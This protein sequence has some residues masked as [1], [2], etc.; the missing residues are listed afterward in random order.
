MKPLPTLFVLGASALAMGFARPSQDAAPAEPSAA[1]SKGTTEP[2][3]YSHDRPA[4]FLIRYDPTRIFLTPHL[5]EALLQPVSTEEAT[6]PTRSVSLNFMSATESQPPGVF[7]GGIH[8]H[9]DA[10]QDLKVRERLL[11]TGVAQL[12]YALNERL[13]QPR[14]RQANES[15]A[16]SRKLL[17]EVRRELNA[18][19]KEL[20]AQSIA[21]NVKVER[22]QLARDL[23][24]LKL[25]L[26]VAE[27]QL[28]E[29]MEEV[30]MGAQELDAVTAKRVLAQQILERVVML[31]RTGNQPQEKLLRA[32]AELTNADQQLLASRAK[33]DAK[34]SNVEFFDQQ[35]TSLNLRLG[36]IAARIA[37]L[38]QTIESDMES[39]G[40]M[41][42]AT[43][44]RMELE[45]TQRILQAQIERLHES[46]AHK[47]EALTSL[48]PVSVERW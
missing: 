17:Q 19:A 20:A 42:N 4:T 40:S 10:P 47:E 48:T 31:V 7:V 34:T 36:L 33:L 30:R 43:A 35:Q 6:D 11:N 32:Q 3:P 39:D 22:E 24:M 21:A 14:Q 9:R 15:R 29:A 5:V 13:T 18:V 44:R 2:L 38:D 12:R 41:I 27:R 1:A 45:V 37:L 25:E 46:I 23:E 16:R 26:P 8:L 28:E